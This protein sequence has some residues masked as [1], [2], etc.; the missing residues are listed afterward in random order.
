MSH[1]TH[2]SHGIDSSSGYER[3]GLDRLEVS[4]VKTSL[5]KHTDINIT[6]HERPRTVSKIHQLDT[7]YAP[8]SNRRFR[9][10]PPH[11]PP[12]P[13]S[14]SL[15]PASPQSTSRSLATP[16]GTRSKRHKGLRSLYRLILPVAGHERDVR[17]SFL[18][19]HRSCVNRQ[20]AVCRAA[21]IQGAPQSYILCFCLPVGGVRGILF[22]VLLPRSSSTRFILS[23]VPSRAVS[24][25]QSWAKSSARSCYWR[26]GEPPPV[27]CF[28]N[29]TWNFCFS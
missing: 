12:P 5:L 2:S 4:F 20:T 23:K 19:S 9:L 27:R 14:S 22:L 6:P 8:L 7:F 17:R 29:T 28:N 25:R 1:K 11:S 13:P 26:R 3:I 10:D 21:R 16:T 24:E 18:I 15:R